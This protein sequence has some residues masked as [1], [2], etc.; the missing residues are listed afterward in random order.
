MITSL[1][2]VF[3]LVVG[4]VGVRVLSSVDTEIT[5]DSSYLSLLESSHVEASEVASIEVP[6]MD[7]KEI[8]IPVQK[9]ASKKIIAKKPAP[10]KIIVEEPVYVSKSELPFHEPVTLQKVTYNVALLEN[11]V[12]L[13]EGL[14]VEEKVLV[15]EEVKK[16]EVK[17]I[18]ASTDAEPEFFEYEAKPEEKAE[19]VEVAAATPAP[20]AEVKTET[21]TETET[22]K[23]VE[24]INVVVQ[25]IQPAAPKA[26]E[27][28]VDFVAF[29]YSGLKQDIKE[30]KVPTISMVDTH[31][32]PKRNSVVK[33]PVQ[34]EKTDKSEKSEKNALVQPVF[35]TQMTIQ[36]VAT[37]LRNNDVLRGFEVR[38][39]DN[40]SESFE[41]YGDGEVTVSLSMA[42]PKM[43]R[44]MVLL[45][46]GFAPTNT[47][48]ILEDGAGSVSI[49][50]L[51]QELLDEQMAAFEKSGPVGAL[52]V[53][54]ADE[55]EKATLDV[56]FGKIITLDG[57]MR[58]TKSEDFRYQ[59]FIGVK[60]GNALLTYV[61]GNEITNKIVHIHEREVTFESNYFEKEKLEK[62]TLFQEDLLSREKSPLVTASENV[63]VFARNAYG[64]KLNQNTYRIDFGKALMG[65]RNYLE[66]TH[67]SEAVFVGTKNETQLSVPSEDL[68]RHILSSLPENKLGNRCV[69]QVN[70]KRKIADV[71][72]ASESVGE[73]LMITAQYLDNDGR[74]YESASEKTRKII[75]VGENHGSE[76]QD[77][78]GK[79]NVKITYL[80]GSQEF[81]GSY[82]SP[83]TYLVEQL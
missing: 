63:K 14:P 17:L 29:D 44:S 4:V 11:M 34:E 49:P 7:F 36:G 23:V 6:E 2:L 5:F 9:V 10:K 80:D 50:V 65:G 83:N 20:V 1:T 45:K 12:A 24:N 41:D 31:R 52:L 76:L 19:V 57:D 40:T 58:E 39:Q 61:H 15:A 22:E 75:V 43:T 42:R 26:E 64:E 71:S 47:D 82:C 55:T 67:E 27:A 48:L 28:K 62:V 78:N 72:V 51:S 21:E 3:A 37:D 38:F 53:E 8:K 35:E 66:L 18:Q 54:L 81:L 56:P 73:S 59:L 46:R 69:I 70:T 33:P 30:N 13:Y 60:A 32:K 77:S 79:V 68:M 25:D 74:F 16:D